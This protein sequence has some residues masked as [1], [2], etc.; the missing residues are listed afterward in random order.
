[1]GAAGEFLAWCE[2]RGIRSLTEVETRDT[3]W[4]RISPNV[5][6]KWNDRFI[7]LALPPFRACIVAKGDAR[8]RLF[9]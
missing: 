4:P 5:Q 7:R 8:Q 2:D 1:M 6:E 9:N 3:H